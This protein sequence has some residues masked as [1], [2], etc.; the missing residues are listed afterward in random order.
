MNTL[1]DRIPQAGLEFLL[2]RVL[3]PRIS[4]DDVMWYVRGIYGAKSANDAE[5]VAVRD[6]VA[7]TLTRMRTTAS[8]R[9]NLVLSPAR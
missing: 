4:A 5:W 1:S 7:R 3:T 2:S 8:T 9:A 6:R